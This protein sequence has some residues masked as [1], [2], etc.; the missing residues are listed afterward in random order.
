[1]S[2]SNFSN[3]D[4]SKQ[5]DFAIVG[6]GISGLYCALRLSQAH[7]TK[8]IAVIERLNRTGGRLNTDLITIQPKMSKL[9]P[10]E[11]PGDFTTVHSGS[12]GRFMNSGSVFSV[13]RIAASFSPFANQP[14][15][16]QQH[17]HR[18]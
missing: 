18:E 10:V 1:M 6:A 8:R 13:S 17:E 4:E 16:A 5:V 7:P 15:F 11:K 14:S 3:L 12:V 9:W 2:I